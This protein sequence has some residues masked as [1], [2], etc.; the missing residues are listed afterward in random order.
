MPTIN[1]IIIESKQAYNNEVE[2]KNG[3]KIIVNS[4]IESVEHINRVGKVVEAPDFTILQKGDEVVVHHNIMRLR[5]GVKGQKVE[6]NF[7]I[8]DNKYF[9]PLTEVFMY[10]RDGGNW[11]AIDPYCFVKPIKKEVE[12][13]GSILLPENNKEGTHKGMLKNMG[14]LTYGNKELEEIG[15][16]EGTQVIFSDDSEYEFVIDNELFYR[17]R[18]KDIIG[19]V[20]CK[21]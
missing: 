21:D 15:V 12:K 3:Q 1:Y 8:E 4:T 11:T 18:T 6:S 9:V 7:H 10:K 2:L 19:I 14:I 13:K 16:E 17:M 5:N 20:E